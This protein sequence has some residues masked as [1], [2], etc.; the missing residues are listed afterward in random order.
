MK[1]VKIVEF[2]VPDI[3]VPNNHP[4]QVQSLL[5]TLEIDYVPMAKEKWFFQ[6]NE[7]HLIQSFTPPERSKSNVGFVTSQLENPPATLKAQCI[8]QIARTAERFPKD[9]EAATYIV[10]FGHEYNDETF[11]V[12][13]FKI[14]WPTYMLSRTSR[15][16]HNLNRT[17]TF[18][19]VRRRYMAE[20]ITKAI[21]VLYIGNTPCGDIQNVS[22]DGVTMKSNDLPPGKL[23]ALKGP[24]IPFEDI[25][26]FVLQPSNFD[27]SQ[28]WDF[29]TGT[30]GY[31]LPYNMIM[32]RR[33]ARKAILGQHKKNELMGYFWN[34]D[35]G[36]GLKQTFL[37][38]HYHGFVHD[39][40]LP[41]DWPV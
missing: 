12:V 34:Y 13:Q 40:P 22:I 36:D 14:N 23:V 1:L 4:K 18:A 30:P 27:L 16:N 38:L 28:N 33:R 41:A 9:I 32:N 24:D 3:N 8:E 11:I 29:S 17:Q 39:F 25:V 20:E 21:Q 19:D 2:D 26:Q 10:G 6:R 31:V 5:E 15:V 7:A 37:R 35:G